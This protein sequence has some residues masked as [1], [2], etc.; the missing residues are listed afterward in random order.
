MDIPKVYLYA[1]RREWEGRRFFMEN[2]R[3]FE[4]YAQMPWGG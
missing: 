4:E 1:L 2:D 3:V